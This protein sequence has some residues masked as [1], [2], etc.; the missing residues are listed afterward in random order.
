MS[1][2]NNLTTLLKS[3][4]PQLLEDEYV[5]CSVPVEQVGTLDVATV[6][7]FRELEGMT[8]ILTR[9]EAERVGLNYEFVFSMIALLVHSSLEAVGFLAAITNTLAQ[10]GISVNAVSAYY[11]DYLF[12]PVEKAKQ[13]MQLLIEMNT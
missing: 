12:V 8:L 10:N 1:G 9:Q 11:H 4:Q 13:V 3:M 2:E 7:Q 5:F 6:C